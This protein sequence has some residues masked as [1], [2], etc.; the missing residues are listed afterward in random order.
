MPPIHSTA[1]MM[2]T[3]KELI[4]YAGTI[5][6]IFHF[7]SQLAIAPENQLSLFLLGIAASHFCIYVLPLRYNPWNPFV[8]EFTRRR[9][10]QQA[11]KA[12]N[13]NRNVHGNGNGD[14]DNKLGRYEQLDMYG[15]EHAFLNLDL[16]PRTMWENVGYWKNAGGDFPKAC[17]ALFEE[18]LNVSGALENGPVS[19]LELGCGCAEAPLHLLKT[20]PA[21]LSNY[22]GLNINRTQAEFCATRLNDWKTTHDGESSAES[23]HPGVLRA[24]HANAATPSCWSKELTT[25]V[26]SSMNPSGMLAGSEI[27]RKWV[28]A[29]DTLYHFMEGREEI[30][31]HVSKQLGAPLIATDF[32]LKENLSFNQRLWL[33]LTLKGIQ[34]PW[35]NRITKPEYIEMLVRCGYERES[36]QIINVTQHVFWDYANFLSKREKDWEEMGGDPAF[37]KPF[38]HF[39]WVLRYWAWAGTI[40]QVL[41]VAHPKK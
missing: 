15:M 10:K 3:L 12:K 30:L 27:P 11:K 24:F 28:L 1:R 2:D 36:I 41:V 7:R 31:T 40:S 19:L 29:L 8:A 38:T 37:A 17:S 14:G 23:S 13:K 39:R 5:G 32:I 4:L 22:V 35:T 34:V 18:L 21:A 26:N 20:R 9:L 6:T 25:T 16:E 33:R